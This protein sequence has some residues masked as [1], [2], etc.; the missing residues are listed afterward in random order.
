[1]LCPQA[2]CGF[3]AELAKRLADGLADG[4]LTP[5]L[6][7]PTARLYYASPEELTN[8]DMREYRVVPPK[9]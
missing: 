2:G 5:V 8:L 6:H 4:S 9:A 3:D 7:I 1:M